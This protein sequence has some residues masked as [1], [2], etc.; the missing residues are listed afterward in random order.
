M[1]NRVRLLQ[2]DG[3]FHTSIDAVLLAAACPAQS[4]QSVIDLGCGV[5][6]AGFCVLERVKDASLTGIDIQEDHINLARQNAELN[7]KTAEFINGDI[8][9]FNTEARFQHVI[10]NPP[11][12][13]DGTHSKSPSAPRAKALGHD[14]TTLEDWITAAFNLIKGQGSLTLIHRADH[15]DKIIHLLTPRFGAVEIIPLWPKAGTQAKRVII[16]CAKHKKTPATLHA[17]IVLHQEN[18]EYTP[19]A[20]NILRGG[21]AIL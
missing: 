6:A 13:E 18:G 7:H 8:K 16:R 21:A 15:I 3:G 1:G 17:G 11:Y 5:G 9:E 19:E 2:P 14:E 12:L 4:G 20:E 10:C